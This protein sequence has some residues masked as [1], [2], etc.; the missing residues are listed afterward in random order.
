MATDIL[1]Y[2]GAYNLSTS[3]PER[4]ELDGKAL[5]SYFAEASRSPTGVPDINLTLDNSRR[6][7]IL[8]ADCPGQAT[9]LL[10]LNR[11]LRGLIADADGKVPE[12]T[13]GLLFADKYAPSDDMFGLMFTRGFAD[14]GDL[15]A[16]PPRIGAVVFAKAIRDARTADADF[17][18]QVAFDCLHELG[19]IFNLWHVS[20]GGN[21]MRVSDPKQ[22][23]HPPFHFV[24]TQQDFLNQCST[25]KFV[26]PGGSNFGDRGD[27]HVDSDESSADAADGLLRF[28]IS[29][30]HEEVF[31]FEPVELDVRVYLARGAKRNCRIPDELDPGYDSFALWITDPNGERRRYRPTHRYCRKTTFRTIAPNCPFERDI[32]IFGQAGGYTFQR[33]G[34]YRLQAVLQRLG[35]RNLL[36]NEIKLMVLP[37]QLRSAE[38]CNL[39]STL[40]H[41]E[42]A[43]VLYYRAGVPRGKG[44]VLL[45]EV[46][47]KHPKTRAAS[48]CHYALGRLFLKHTGTG[49][50][51]RQ[52]STYWGRAHDHFSRAMDSKHFTGHRRVITENLLRSI[53][54]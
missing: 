10:W 54:L 8:N 5:P 18:Q 50:S 28:Q 46:C 41:P 17:N 16:K 6:Q 35:S 53:A 36:S 42:A 11:A 25:S 27:L 44:A 1:C 30:S 4:L 37:S 22:L 9:E 3:L 51:S 19:H 45:Q 40:A 24:R 14:G 52:K 49:K 13:I 7:R 29:I 34:T 43:T 32:T 38:Y 20:D 12:R 23:Y 26:T 47:L 15:Y 33:A 21:P 39:R 2:L 48:A 31:F